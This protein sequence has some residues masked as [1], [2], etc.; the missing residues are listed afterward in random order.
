MTEKTENLH[1]FLNVNIMV[2]VWLGLDT[3]MSWNDHVLGYK[4]Y[5][6]KARETLW[7]Y[8]NR[9]IMVRFKKKN[10]IDKK[11][12]VLYLVKV[13]CLSD[14]FSLTSSQ[15]GL[16]RSTIMSPYCSYRALSLE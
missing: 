2:E 12:T 1:L 4:K 3:K 8:G 5:F 11:Q 14:P 6:V 13:Q 10:V 9:T 15:C 16:C 7:F